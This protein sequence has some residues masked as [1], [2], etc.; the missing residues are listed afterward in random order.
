MYANNSSTSRHVIEDILIKF[1]TP[2]LCK[3]SSVAVESAKFHLQGSIT[4]PKVQR[5]LSTVVGE[6]HHRIQRL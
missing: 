5:W 6:D 2:R 4:L 1:V 3:E